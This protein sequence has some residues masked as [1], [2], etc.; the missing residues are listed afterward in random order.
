LKGLLRSDGKDP[1]TFLNGVGA[2]GFVRI[3]SAFLSYA[4]ARFRSDHGRTHL[5]LLLEPA[6]TTSAVSAV[7]LSPDGRALDC[8]F[9]FTTGRSA[10]LHGRIVGQEESDR[11][12]LEIACP[13]ESDRTVSCQLNQPSRPSRE[14]I[15][16]EVRGQNLLQLRIQGDR[17]EVQAPS[18]R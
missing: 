18:Q 2:D 9:V 1:D 16:K 8:A 6:T 12:G 17:F 3:P 15:L 13:V 7:L 5:I 10:D 4:A 14:V 11:P